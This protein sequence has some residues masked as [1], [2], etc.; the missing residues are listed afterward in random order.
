ME[1]SEHMRGNPKAPGY[2]RNPEAS[3]YRFHPNQKTTSTPDDYIF[4]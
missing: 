4:R 1:N 3:P 2:Q